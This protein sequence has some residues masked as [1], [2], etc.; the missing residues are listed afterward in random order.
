MTRR[1]SCCSFLLPFVCVWFKSMLRP[2]Q[3]A[4]LLR[5]CVHDAVNP[6]LSRPTSFRTF[7]SA[8]KPNAS[9]LLHSAKW[10][11]PLR[12]SPQTPNSLVKRQLWGRSKQTPI[13][14]RGSPSDEESARDE[15][16][17][18]AFK[19]RQPAALLMRCTPTPHIKRF[20]A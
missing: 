17:G 18:M 12:H 13:Y 7:S 10:H 5:V 16:L 20:T 9:S 11:N 3:V 2:P 15:I 19:G 6:R 4:V 1:F 14:M 8:V